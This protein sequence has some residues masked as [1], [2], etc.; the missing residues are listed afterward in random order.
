[1]INLKFSKEKRFSKIKF[2]QFNDNNKIS[3]STFKTNFFS[4]EN[5][6][7]KIRDFK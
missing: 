1:M 6:G 2:S 3:N 5:N 7:K 4:F